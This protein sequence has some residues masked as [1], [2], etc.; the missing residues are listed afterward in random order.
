MPETCLCGVDVGTTGTKAV[1]IREDGAVLAEAFEPSHLRQPEPGRVEQDLEEMLG[2]TVEAVARCVQQSGV[3][4]QH[5]AAISF[6][7][8]M[9]GICLIDEEWHPLA[10]YDSWLDTRCAP[11]AARMRAASE[12]IV[13]LTGGPPSYTHGPKILW[14][15]H[16]RPEIFSRAAKVIMPAAYVA[17]ALAG[18][19]ADQAY[20][21]PT[22]LHFSCLSD[23]RAGRYT[24]ELTAHFQVPVEKLP[25]VVEP[26]EVVGRLTGEAAGRLGLLAGTPIVAGAG[27]QAAAMLGAGILRPGMV[28]D[29]AGTASVFAPCVARFSPDTS[30]HT[31]LTARLI[32]AGLWYVIGYINGGGL[33][34][35]WFRDLLR[36][37]GPAED[38]DYPALDAQAAALSPGAD[39]LVFVPHLGGRVC[40]NQPD[41]RGAWLG[42]TWAHGLAHLYRALLE[43]VAYEYAIY[44]A[45]ARELV[46]ET[47][48]AEVRVVGGGARS[49][50]WNQVKADVLGLTYIRLNRTEA[51]ALG[52]AILAGYAV[53][54][55][56]DW[57][58]AVGRFTWPVE[59]FLPDPERT[60]RYAPWVSLYR[61]IVED[62]ALWRRLSDLPE[63]S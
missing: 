12:R 29:A 25:R 44:L 54:V 9:A 24:E 37:A 56:K 16:E 47:V 14:W 23:T 21:D 11:Y 20:I 61:Q 33:N 57:A 15:K 59:R 32:P 17:G 55:F 1:I 8:Q 43:S 63:G 36:A 60:A 46:P 5:I 48:F 28:Y 58:E 6:D 42:L 19:R 50:L 27:D 62:G 2:E 26:W 51:A 10:P 49:A 38:W 41:L 13:A 45:L 7:G 40:P 31:L 22:Y 30:H 4:P 53:G 52:S 34:L 3:P 18:L 39:R 35:R